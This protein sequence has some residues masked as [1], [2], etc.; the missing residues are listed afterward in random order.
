MSNCLV[1]CSPY[2]VCRSHRAQ[3][4]ATE[5][6]GVR[7]LVLA[8]L[9]VASFAA[10]AEAE[11]DSSAIRTKPDSTLLVGPPTASQP[12]PLAEPAPPAAV[13]QPAVPAAVQPA[14]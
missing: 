2:G 12:F 8:A 1:G 9:L 11:N 14:E 5:G 6:I 10:V 7:A 3:H 4:V 13:P